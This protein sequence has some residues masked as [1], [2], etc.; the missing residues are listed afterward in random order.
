MYAHGAYA[1]HLPL[2]RRQCEVLLCTYILH[3]N[4]N[5]H[6][7]NCSSSGGDSKTYKAIKTLL[8]AS[9][10]PPRIISTPVI[11]SFEGSR[12]KSLVESTFF[13]T[14]ASPQPQS[15]SSSRWAQSNSGL[16]RRALTSLWT[17]HSLERGDQQV[18]EL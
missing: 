6:I 16:F 1:Q 11:S 3:L 8:A 12:S 15:Y 17:A 7:K 14:G 2:Q 5:K 9:Y 18:Q 13:F 4:L 10:L